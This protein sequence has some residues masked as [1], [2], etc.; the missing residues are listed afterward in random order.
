VIIR[1]GPAPADGNWLPT[2][3]EKSWFPILRLYGPLE[4]WFDQTWWPGEVQPA[5]REEHPHAPT[6]GAFASN[7]KSRSS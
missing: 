4:P 2:I 6:G 1:F 5:W 3:P 7:R